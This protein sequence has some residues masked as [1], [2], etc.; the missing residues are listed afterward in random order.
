MGSRGSE[1][2]EK[3]K[4][5]RTGSGY[6]VGSS[7]SGIKGMRTGDKSDDFTRKG[8]GDKLNVDNQFK[9]GRNTTDEYRKR[10]PKKGPNAKKRKKK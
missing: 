4:Y 7:A 9:R 3:K 2:K 8:I 5:Q 1:Y 6:T 10:K